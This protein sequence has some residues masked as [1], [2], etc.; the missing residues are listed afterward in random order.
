MNKQPVIIESLAF[1]GLFYLAYKFLP[2]VAL[3][4]AFLLKILIT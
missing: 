3:V 4:V 2:I 1:I